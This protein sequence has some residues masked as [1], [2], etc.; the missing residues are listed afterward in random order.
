MVQQLKAYQRWTLLLLVS[1][2][3]GCLVSWSVDEAVESTKYAEVRSPQRGILL[4]LHSLSEHCD[5]Q[6]NSWVQSWSSGSSLDHCHVWAQSNEWGAAAA[7]GGVREACKQS[8]AR[9]NCARICCVFLRSEMPLSQSASLV[10]LSLNILRDTL[11]GVA[12]RSPSVSYG[13]QPCEDS[14]FPYS[15]YDEYSREFTGTGWCDSCYTML[16]TVRLQNVRDLL[17]QTFVD[18]VPGHFVEAG[19][20]RGGA[21][22]FARAVQRL[23]SEGNLRRTYVCDSFEG[24]PDGEYTKAHKPWT[25]TFFNNTQE[26][27]R[28]HFSRFQMLDSNV[29]FIK[30]FFLNSL[31]ALRREFAAAGH[32]ISVLRC[33]SDMFGS[34]LDILY[35][36]Y[37][38]VSVGGFVICDDCPRAPGTMQAVERFREH[39]NMTEKIHFIKDTTI[40]TFWRKE[41]STFIDYENFIR[42]RSKNKQA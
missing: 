15:P 1:L 10:E 2:G 32:R 35:N 38:F 5:A 22:I 27:V 33:D 11:T 13:N 41:R 25:R 20:W 23:H 4:E 31:P 21:S 37:E 24:F 30:G 36:L 12:V 8:W 26:Q 6:S 17:E 16:S 42:W 39:N 7:Q 18:N 29:H 34:T 19:A 9:E 14:P 40:G 28:D 3:I